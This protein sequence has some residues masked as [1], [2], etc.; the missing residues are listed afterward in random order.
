MTSLNDTQMRAPT[1]VL[2]EFLK[3]SISLADLLREILSGW[4]IVAAALVLGL[5]YGV[6]Q[7]HRAGPLFTA[8]ISVMPAPTDTEAGGGGSSMLASLAGS[9]GSGQVPKFAQFLVA[10]GSVGVAERL[11]RQYDMVCVVYRGLCDPRTH[12]WQKR[13]GL[14]PAFNALLARIGGLPDPNGALTV[15]DLA[16]HNFGAVIVT[17]EK[18]SGLVTLSYS[19]RDPKFAADYLSKVVRTTNDYIRQKD[20]AIQRTYVAY[21]TQRI[22]ENTNVEQRATLDNL[23]L[24]QERRLM[25][26]EVDVPYAAT[27]LD[28]PT[29]VPQNNVLRTILLNVFTA[30]LIG[31][32]IAVTRHLVPRRWRFWSRT[33]TRS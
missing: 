12:T 2:R 14:I 5:M 15:V 3:R 24:Q 18:T 1:V 31:V 20:R 30:L 10:L 22:A 27:I 19:N 21:V 16:A 8:S 9:E 23:L 29:V 11:D 33:W 25:M 17:R 6:Y 7:A 26:T 28:G 13:K 4:W 32:G